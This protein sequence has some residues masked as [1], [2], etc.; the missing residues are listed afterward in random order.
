MQTRQ[1][2]VRLLERFIYSIYSWL[3]KADSPTKKQLQERVER[4][5]QYL[6]KMQDKPVLYKKQLSQKQDLAN[7]I[8]SLSCSDKSV[9][10]IIQILSKKLNTLEKDQNNRRYK[11]QNNLREDY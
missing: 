2:Y 11:R 5:R 10:E 4:A 3:K 7:E 6:D 8:I 9:E 1:K